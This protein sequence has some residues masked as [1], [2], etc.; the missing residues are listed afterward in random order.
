VSAFAVPSRACPPGRHDGI[1]LHGHAAV[2][3]A[4]VPTPAARPP[5]TP[6]L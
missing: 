5:T 1:V 4:A 2:T 3:G 6:A